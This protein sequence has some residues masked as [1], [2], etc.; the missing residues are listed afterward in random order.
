LE[1]ESL[2]AFMAQ[3]VDD[4]PEG[5][6]VAVTSKVVALSQGR[7]LPR[8]STIAKHLALRKES[9]WRRKA[10]AFW[11]TITQ[12]MF[13]ANAGIDESNAN[14]KLVLLPKDVMAVAH[15]LRRMLMRKHKRKHLGVVITDSRVFPLRAG[16]TGVAIGYAGFKG[17]RDYRGTKD[18]F[19][20]KLVHTR[21]NVADCLASAA[22]L[23]MGEGAERT[24]LAII[25]GAPVEFADRVPKDELRIAPKDDLYFP[26]LR[27]R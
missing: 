10:G 24:P 7:T 22:V 11:I 14:G 2:A 19:G 18:L 27:G 3:H 12:G 20:R 16:V 15:E 4:L 6:I 17:A 23:V 5:A 25:T 21:T 1:K 26:L 9:S 8:A 13:M